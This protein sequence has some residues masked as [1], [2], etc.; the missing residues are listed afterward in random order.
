[1]KLYKLYSNNS[2][3]KDV[4]FND[5]FNVVL[6][7]V[8][9]ETN[10]DN[11]AHN[12]GKST[13]IS[14]IDFM[15]LK[16]LKKDHFLKKETFKNYI[17]YMEI[18]LNSGEYV[19]IKRPVAKNTKISLAKHNNENYDAREWEQWDYT[20][21]SLGTKD[22]ESNPKEILNRWLGFDVLVG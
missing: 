14:L 22:K 17:F 18:K 3:F 5:G 1:M 12:L 11:D 2:E 15:L 20:D 13:L 16:E 6:G 9:N 21:L 4:N 8:S 19:T 7:E 10:L